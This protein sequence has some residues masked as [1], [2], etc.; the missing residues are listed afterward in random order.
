[1]KIF[2]LGISGTFMGNLA[3][4]AKKKGFE[5]FGVDQKFY[6]PMSDE[7]LSA[8]IKF[9]EGYEEKN[10]ID[11]DLYVIGNS[12]SRGNLLLEVIIDKNKKIISA[13]DWLYQYVLN[14]KKVIA[15]SGTHGKTTVTSM[16]AHAFKRDGKNDFGHLIAGVP[17][18]IHSW[19]LGDDD[20]FVIESDE[21][22]TAYFD[23]EPKF[24]HYRPNILIINNI[25]FDHADIYSS[26]DEIESKFIRLLK[27][28]EK[29]S[30]AYINTGAIRKS[31][32]DKVQELE[33]NCEI[34]FF[35]AQGETISETN[36]NLA[37]K[38][39][40]NFFD[41]VTA[42]KLLESFKGV[43]RRFQLLFESEKII[44][45]NDFAHHPTAI[46]RTIELAQKEFVDAEIIPIIEFGSNTMRNGQHDTSLRDILVNFKSYTINSSEKQQQLFESFSSVFSQNKFDEIL[47]SKEKK[48]VVLMCGNRDFNGLQIQFLNKLKST[49]SK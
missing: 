37:S 25:E 10:F 16:I 18:E 14:E 32:K 1:M 15:V 23:K 12:I 20:Y 3:Q 28:M 39:L 22:D 26:V 33:T 13:P 38:V 4:I 43:K 19:S 41:K 8:G 30:R 6:P 24:F 49:K 45:I 11:A 34:E 47:N 40:V 44:L 27:Q 17:E 35:N 21:Y 36:T 46:L 48:I 5:V 31:F 29:G 42:K 7:L 9:Q 2:F